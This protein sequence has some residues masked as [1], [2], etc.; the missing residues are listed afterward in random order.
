MVIMR[1]PEIDL[2]GDEAGARGWTLI[3]VK[4]IYTAQQ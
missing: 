3:S 4:T 2:V 1:L